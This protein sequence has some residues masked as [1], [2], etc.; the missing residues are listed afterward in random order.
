M[1]AVEAAARRRAIYGVEKYVL[2]MGKVV[3][4]KDRFINGDSDYA[5][6]DASILSVDTHLELMRAIAKGR[7]RP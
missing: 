2:N 1:D 3:S 4:D 7:T 6:P 5:L